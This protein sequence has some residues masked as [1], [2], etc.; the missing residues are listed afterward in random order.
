MSEVFLCPTGQL[1]NVARRDLRKAGIVVVEVE[2]PSRCQF[3][4][5]TEVISG[6]DMLWATFKALN[7][8]QGDKAISAR[9]QREEL[10]RNL[11][12]II[13]AARTKRGGETP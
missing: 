13:D 7:H 9:R 4:R 3:I 5:S 12:H 1:S 8:Q 11:M 2:D 6:D 10:A